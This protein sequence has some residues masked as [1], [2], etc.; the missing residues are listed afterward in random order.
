MHTKTTHIQTKSSCFSV[1]KA[2][3]SATNIRINSAKKQYISAS[4][5]PPIKYYKSK[6]YTREFFN[7]FSRSDA[8]S[9][10]FAIFELRSYMT[11]WSRHSTNKFALCSRL[12]PI[13]AAPIYTPRSRHSTNK[14][15][16]CSRLWLIWAAPIY[17]PWSRHSPNKFGLCS[18]L[19]LYLC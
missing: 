14:F 13:W 9:R 17:T 12:W 5:T 11:S 15:G 16:L 2:N 7:V 6:I 8:Y 4:F 19:W 3:G 1:L 10:L 18:R